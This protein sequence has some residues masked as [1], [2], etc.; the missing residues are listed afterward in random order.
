MGTL[1]FIGM[2]GFFGIIVGICDLVLA[3][4]AERRALAPPVG[5]A[6]SGFH[7]RAEARQV[8]HNYE[9]MMEDIERMVANL[10]NIR[11][12]KIE[13]L[14]ILQDVMDFSDAVKRMIK[15]LE[16]NEVNEDTIKRCQV[17]ENKLRIFEDR[18]AARLAEIGRSE[19][20][21]KES[22]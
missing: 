17:A 9:G 7:R 16:A 20:R 8:A 5:M 3:S 22:A 12:N 1:E 4:Q 19:A 10:H 6:G 14:N 11:V 13:E 2:L 15:E 21:R 18:L